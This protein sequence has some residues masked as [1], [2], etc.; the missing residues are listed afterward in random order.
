MKR[1][2]TQQ[3]SENPEPTRPAD[4]NWRYLEFRKLGLTKLKEI[5]S[6]Q[7][8]IEQ[9][10]K[11]PFAPHAIARLRLSAYQ[12][13]R[14]MKYIDNLLDWGDNLFARDTVE[15]I[16]E[17]SMLYSLAADILGQRPV[18]LGKCKSPSEARMTYA[19]IGPVIKEGSEFIITLEN[20][21]SLLQP[22]W[23]LA[24]REGSRSGIYSKKW[25]PRS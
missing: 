6:D 19:E 7:A 14:V 1:Y 20:W 11:D 5:L 4:R 16:N 9:Y 17:A 15:S 13:G 25:P 2:S 18:Q 3:P 8:A 22:H 24:F 23:R 12:K 21:P 10:K